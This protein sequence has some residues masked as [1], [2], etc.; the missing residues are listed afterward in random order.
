MKHAV[1]RFAFA[2]LFS[3]G[4]FLHAA[5]QTPALPTKAGVIK[6]GKVE[7]AASRLTAD[8]QSLAI[9]PGDVLIESDTVRTT[10]GAM[11]VL[12]FANGSSV[13]VGSE[14][15][16]RIEE[17]KMDPLAEDVQ[18]AKLTSEPSVSLTT[19]NLTRG[20]LIGDVKHLNEKG[21]SH[22]KINTPVGAAGIRGTQFRIK[23]VPS[24]DGKTFTFTLSTADGKVNFS[25]TVQAPA[26]V[27]VP[28]DQELVVTAEAT[29]DTTTGT[30]TVQSIQVPTTTT[31]ISSEAT[32]AITT[33][34]TQAVEAATDTIITVTEQ[35]Q[36]KDQTQEQPKQEQPKQEQKQEQPKQEGTGTPDTTGRPNNVTSGSGG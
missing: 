23:F 10:K 31:T 19:L 13:K 18:V 5:A 32:Q 35:Q 24:G 7:G 8:G 34:V 28:K 6:V 1:L 3:L 15:V 11:V 16:L 25:G 17:F 9:K 26:N 12:V 2:A 30:V 20:E 29:V 14:S 36:Q 21:G 4:L 22:F 33:A 27:D